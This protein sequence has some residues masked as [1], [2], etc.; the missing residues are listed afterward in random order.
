MVLVFSSNSNSSED[1]GRE[2]MLAANSKLIIIPFKIE[3]VEPEPGKQY[4]LARTH[5]LD[6]MNPPT[7]EQITIL[8]HRVKSILPATGS[9]GTKQT[10]PLRELQPPPPEESALKKDQR[11]WSPV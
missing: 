2:L 6:A 10:E 1:V 4:Y 9:D 5:W 7:K 8:V 3:N 11:K